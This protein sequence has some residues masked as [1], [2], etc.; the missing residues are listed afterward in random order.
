MARGKEKIEAECLKNTKIENI[1]EQ[2]SR[3]KSICI[4][5]C[6]QKQYCQGFLTFP[7]TR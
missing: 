1:E 2:G 5:K 6:F 7:T 3:L 4:T